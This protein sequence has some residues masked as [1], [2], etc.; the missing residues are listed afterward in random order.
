MNKYQDGTEEGESITLT[1]SSNMHVVELSIGGND[2]QETREGYNVLD[3]LGLSLQNQDKGVTID[4]SEDGY[5]TANGTSTQSYSVY[6]KDND[7][8]SKLEDGETYSIWQENYSKTNNGGVY[9]QVIAKPIGGGADVFITASMQ[10]NTF[11]VDKSKYTYQSS[12]QIGSIET[13]GTFNNYKNRYMIYKGTDNKEFELYGAMPS[14]SYP[15]EVETVGS[16]LSAFNIADYLNAD[17]LEITASRYFAYAELPDIFKTKIRMNAKEITKTT[18]LAFGLI[19][20]KYD[21][22]LPTDYRVLQTDGRITEKFYDFSNSE[23]VYLFVADSGYVKE[24]DYNTILSNY[25]IEITSCTEIVI[26]DVNNLY[27][28][29]DMLSI[30]AEIE[31]KEDNYMT[32]TV[33]NTSGQSTLFKNF[34]TNASK[35][36]KPN[37]DYWV[38]LEIKEVTG[39]GA[40]QLASMD[41]SPQL[42]AWQDYNFS[43]LSAN[44]IIVRKITSDANS[45][46]AIMLLRSFCA[47]SAGQSGSI[48]FRLSI[49]PVE[50]TAENFKYVPF[51][52]QTKVIDTQQ[53]MLEGDYFVKEVDG[54][55]EVHGW[56]K[57]ILDGTESWLLNSSFASVFYT[58]QSQNEFLDM[59]NNIDEY[60]LLCNVYKYGGIVSSSANIQDNTIC[61]FKENEATIFKR[62]NL[63][64]TRFTTVEEFT[65][66]LAQ[67]YEEGNP[68]YI[69]YKLATPEK[70]TCTE[71]Q[72]AQLDDL[73]KTH[74]YK[75]VTHI[76]STDK[77]SPKIKV[78]YRK[79]IETMFNKQ[80]NDY[81]TRLSNIEKLLTTTTTSAM[82]LD[83]LQT[84]IEQEVM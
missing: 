48:T 67:K 10:K 3:I 34:F 30:S 36:I 24:A 52:Q 32:C 46:N 69:W 73:L 50:V 45:N 7:L 84:D 17:K 14:P 66:W 12:I 5:I 11:T 63:K 6:L 16:D 23:H 1:D 39:T 9:L 64:D 49:S 75:N 37:T 74:T 18:K 2:K 57:K 58:K 54:W 56:N 51:M 55:K 26:N 59:T 78:V 68:V 82:L 71:K 62:L 79:D 8:S 41:N 35:L 20:K 76:Y 65:N 60:K 47:F 15:S 81:D 44:K 28:N 72:S 25:N 38:I 43:V 70:L 42:G 27:N 53:K 19:D 83:N 29:K 21:M 61:G 77:V 22:G 80:Q 13:A 33:D 4:R 31:Y 40:F